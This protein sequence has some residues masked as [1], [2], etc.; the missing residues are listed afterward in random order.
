AALTICGGTDMATPTY[1]ILY[2]KYPDKLTNEIPNGHIMDM[3]GLQFRMEPG[4]P[5]EPK[6]DEVSFTLKNLDHAGAEIY[7]R[8]WFENAARSAAEGASV[9]L[10]LFFRIE[11]PDYGAHGFTGVLRKKSY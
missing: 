1:R 6:V 11:M 4:K 3:S 9:P 2:G 5:G 10:Q 8:S 7:P